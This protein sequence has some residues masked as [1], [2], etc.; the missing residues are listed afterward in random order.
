[1]VKFTQLQ[2]KH[3]ILL[4]RYE[5]LA[6]DTL[7]VARRLYDFLGSAMPSSVREWIRLNTKAKEANGAMGTHR[8]SSLVAERWRD[9]LPP[10]TKRII[11]SRCLDVLRYLGY[12][13][14]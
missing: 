7:T 1:M 11:N 3:Q 8:N 13:L 5:D 10:F 2:D 12:P 14:Q 6:L 4:L 9:L